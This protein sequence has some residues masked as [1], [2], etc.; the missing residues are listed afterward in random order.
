MRADVSK[1]TSYATSKIEQA[2]SMAEV[3]DNKSVK[4]STNGRA[5]SA[6]KNIW[7]AVESGVGFEG[8]LAEL[9]V[10]TDLEVAPSLVESAPTGVVSL[11]VL[12]R[13][14]PAA[15]RAAL[16]LARQEKVPEEGENKILAFLKAQL[17]VRSLRPK[18]G[19]SADAIL[20]RA[21]VEVD[22]GNLELA[23]S[24][25]LELPDSS[26]VALQSW[27]KA[28]GQRLAVLTALQKLASAL[29]DN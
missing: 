28:A 23:L 8:H 4:L 7:V 10:V 24:E 18:D 22:R 13:R 6:L 27:S 16:K 20:S 9:A 5:N 14:F 21:V 26:K 29:T 15:A 17:G 2:E 25:I 12:Q 3:L 19:T 1:V 11:I